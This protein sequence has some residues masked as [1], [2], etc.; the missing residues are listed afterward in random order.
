MISNKSQDVRFLPATRPSEPRSQKLHNL[1]LTLLCDITWS[2]SGQTRSRRID[3]RFNLAKDVASRI[4]IPRWPPIHTHTLLEKSFY[5]SWQSKKL[6][7]LY[8]SGWHLLLPYE[9]L[10]RLGQA[11]PQE[12]TLPYEIPR[13]VGIDPVPWWDFG[14]CDVGF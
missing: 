1:C 7:P 3:S 11:R 6:N 12:F 2:M 5:D 8:W 9:Y 14:F 10:T 13:P 4:K